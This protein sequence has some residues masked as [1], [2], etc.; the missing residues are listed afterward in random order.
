MKL[1]PFLAGLLGAVVALGCASTK[2]RS[3][4]ADRQPVYVDSVEAPATVPA[5][6]EFEVKVLGNLPNPAWEIVD[7]EVEKGDR[8]LTITLWGRAGSEGPV[9]QVLEPFEREV[10]V[11]G[12]APG[13]WTIE[14]VGHGG[15][16]EKVDVQVQ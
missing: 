15:T 5:G 3:N 11:E 14:V 1:K 12:L 7:V 16:G 9:I 2:A 4:E 13:K 6:R 10:P 8:R